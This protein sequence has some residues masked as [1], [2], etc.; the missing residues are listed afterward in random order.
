[1]PFD[2]LVECY[3]T[4]RRERGDLPNET[5]RRQVVVREHEAAAQT[6]ERSLQRR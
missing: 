6:A 2:E 4:S 1:M 5:L 3:G